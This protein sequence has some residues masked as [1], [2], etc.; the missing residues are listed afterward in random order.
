MDKKAKSFVKI[1]TSATKVFFVRVKEFSESFGV[2][3][4]N[5]QNSIFMSVKKGQQKR[6]IWNRILLNNLFP[7]IFQELTYK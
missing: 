3:L 1:F 7:S 5:S 2:F 6:Q 4:C